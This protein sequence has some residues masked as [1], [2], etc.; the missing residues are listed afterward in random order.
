MQISRVGGA[1]CFP[2]AIL[3]ERLFSDRYSIPTEVETFPVTVDNQT[4]H[5]TEIQDLPKYFAA[6][7][8]F[9]FYILPTHIDDGDK[10]HILNLAKSRILFRSFSGSPTCVSALFKENRQLIRDLCNFRLSKVHCGR[11][12]IS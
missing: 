9:S 10:P 5:I 12:C 2:T 6:G 8:R 4:D 1:Y 11:G 7:D 3:L